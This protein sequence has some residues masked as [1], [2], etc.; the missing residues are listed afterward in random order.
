MFR[1]IEAKTGKWSIVVGTV[2]A[3]AAVVAALLL[4]PL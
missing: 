2:I 4:Q 3:L 1:Q